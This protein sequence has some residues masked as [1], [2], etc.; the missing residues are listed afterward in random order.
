MPASLVQIIEQSDLPSALR[1]GLI[2]AATTEKPVRSVNWMARV[3]GRS[4]RW[5]ERL[6][7]EYA[8]S[9][10]GY[11]HELLRQ[12]LVSRM[13]A[14]R[15]RGVSWEKITDAFGLSERSIRRYVK[16]SVGVSPKD[17][18]P[19]VAQQE[20]ERIVDAIRSILDA[21]HRRRP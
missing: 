21:S 14:A 9:S 1:E 5:L 13:L 12:V 3:T 8:G 20:E 10:N 2:A 17:L 15:S 16:R 19:D 6:W 4:P 7:R 18:G 11:L